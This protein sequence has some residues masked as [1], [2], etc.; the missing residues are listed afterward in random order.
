[1]LVG[2]RAW[3]G[4]PLEEHHGRPLVHDMLVAL[5]ILKPT[6]KRTDR[7]CLFG[8]SCHELKGAIDQALRV[9]GDENRVFSIFRDE[10]LG[11]IRQNIEVCPGVE[12]LEPLT[13]LGRG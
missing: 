8:N 5:E 10:I 2:A 4:Q 9:E 11:D 3:P 12:Q 6:G 13:S 1:M 7:D